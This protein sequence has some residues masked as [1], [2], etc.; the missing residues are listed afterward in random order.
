MKKLIA[1]ALAAVMALGPLAV[2]SPAQSMLSRVGGIYVA[3]NYAKWYGSVVAGIPAA[4]TAAITVSNPPAL[5]DGRIFIPYFVGQ[6]LSVDGDTQVLTAAVAVTCPNN[7]VGSAGCTQVTAA[8]AAAHPGGQNDVTTST[9]GL[10]EAIWDAHSAGGQVVIDASWGGTNANI[11]AA[12]VFPLATIMDTRS[13]T[14]IAWNPTPTGLNLAVPTTL[15]S[16]AACDSTHQFCSDATVAGSASWGSTV[17]GCVAYV[18]IMGNEGPC[19]ATSTVFTS[20]ASKA[21]DVAAPAASAGAV[22][23]V[24]YLSLSGGTYALAY[25]VPSTSSNC[26]LTTLETTTPACAVAN[27]TY[28]QSASTFGAGGLF[29]KGGSQITTYPV[30]TAMSYPILA[31]TAETLLAQHPI[32]NS[33]LTYSYAP[34]NRVGACQGMSSANTVTLNSASGISAGSATTVPNPLVTWTVPANCFNYIGAEFRVSGMLT[35]TDA[36]SGTSTILTVSWDANGT[37]TTS[38]PLKLCQINDTFTS[39]SG[40]DNV[41]F[42]CTAKVLTTGATGTVLA[43]GQSV[44]AI[45]A[46]ATTLMRTSLSA[47]VAASGSVNLTTNARISAMFEAVGQTTTTG[48][49]TIDATLEFLN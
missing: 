31:T 15:T 35:Y 36:G 8:W 5:P 40:A 7:A 38:V 46:G 20:V 25:Q 2:G 34:S 16:Q 19:S 1:Y 22:G 21:I 41:T 6:H 44:G 23:Y 39:V 9:G 13:G 32:S 28:N 14:P 10:E 3:A 26:T 12:P 11:T 30:N 4:A 29:T 37:N 42:S 43:W 17:Y 24:V 27:T 33:S 47:A 45:A 48:A 49:Q 18:D